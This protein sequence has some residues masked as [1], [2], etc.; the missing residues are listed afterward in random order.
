M[1]LFEQ[2]IDFNYLYISF[3]R[4]VSELIPSKRYIGL[5]FNR[6]DKVKFEVYNPLEDLVGCVL[7]CEVNNV[8]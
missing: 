4:P 8:K 7:L 2:I 3:V 5:D 1:L 6:V